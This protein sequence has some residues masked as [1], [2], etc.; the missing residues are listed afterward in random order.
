ML[1]MSPQWVLRLM[2]GTLLMVMPVFLLRREPA[3]DSLP[4]RNLGKLSL[5]AALW[6]AI[7]AASHRPACAGEVDVESQRQEPPS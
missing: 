4:R 1:Y 7:T 6:E 5:R 3:I 2:L